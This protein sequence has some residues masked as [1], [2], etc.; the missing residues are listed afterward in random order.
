MLRSKIKGWLGEGITRLGLW[1]SL[2]KTLYRRVHNAIVPSDTGTTQIDHIVVSVFGI[3][4]VETKNY[5]GLI[6]GSKNDIEWTQVLGGKTFKFQNPLLQNYRHVRCL[7][8]H[9]RLDD[10]VFRPIVF[11]IGDCTLKG[12]V[13]TNV[14]TGGL[15]AHIRSYQT[16]ILSLNQCA[17]IVQALERLKQDPTLSAVAHRESLRARHRATC[18]NCGGK[19]VVRK[20]RVGSG[21]PF[22]GCVSYP[23]C[24][25]TRPYIRL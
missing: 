14:L 6:L 23:G 8:E 1:A 4:V 2:D 7:S 22:L 24:T 12:D 25:Y 21:Q 17:L 19:L 5:N 16:A 15:T 11:F 20:A 18:P 13:P 3:F 9:L 10:E